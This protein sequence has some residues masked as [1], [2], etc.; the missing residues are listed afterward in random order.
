[1]LRRWHRTACPVAVLHSVEAI[2]FFF[3]H[4]G[5]RGKG[6]PADLNH[7]ADSFMAAAFKLSMLV[8]HYWWFVLGQD[9]RMRASETALVKEHACCIEAGQACSSV[10]GVCIEL[11]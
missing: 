11:S 8:S 3:H 7:E 1:M 6:Y 5:R 2:A 10:R 9:E 4:L